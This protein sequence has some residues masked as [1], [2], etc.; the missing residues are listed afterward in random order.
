MEEVEEEA[1]PKECVKYKV[2]DKPRVCVLKSIVSLRKEQRVCPKI[3]INR[4]II[5][6]WMEIHNVC[7]FKRIQIALQTPIKV[8]LCCHCASFDDLL[9]LFCLFPIS[10]CMWCGVA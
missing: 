1:R 10:P 2:E 9:S 6:I 5:I 8:S 4:R 3:G 7:I